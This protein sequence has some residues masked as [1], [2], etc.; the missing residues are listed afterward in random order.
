M[1]LEVIKYLLAC[2]GGILGVLT[3]VIGWIGVRIH[4]RLDSISASLASIERDLRDDIENHGVRLAVL[5]SRSAHH[6]TRETD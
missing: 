6:R 3:L 4:N 5:E 1:E 2:L